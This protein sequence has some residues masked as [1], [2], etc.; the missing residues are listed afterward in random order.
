M[1]THAITYTNW[2]ALSFTENVHYYHVCKT[3]PQTFLPS[4]STDIA[5]YAFQPLRIL[6]WHNGHRHVHRLVGYKT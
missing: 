3:F 2:L 6:C 1:A 4:I 5:L